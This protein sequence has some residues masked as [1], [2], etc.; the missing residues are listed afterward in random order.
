MIPPAALRGGDPPIVH[1]YHPTVGNADANEASRAA[2]YAALVTLLDA[3]PMTTITVSDVT[4]EA[5]VSRPTFYR[6]FEKL[7]DIL[8]ARL[9][10]LF[11]DFRAEAS[12]SDRSTRELARLFFTY[13]RAH[14]VLID[15]LDRAGLSSEF[16]HRI[17]TYLGIVT[18]DDVRWLAVPHRERTL[19][20]VAGGLHA[21]LIAWTRDGMREDVD[22]MARIVELID[23]GTGTHRDAAR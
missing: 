2:L 4:R 5:G 23:G 15:L 12:V 21:L 7:G 18:A 11:D 8:I 13:F 14:H 17:R 22:E 20:Y 3:R 6:N 10:E 16:Q 19:D 9:D 1:W